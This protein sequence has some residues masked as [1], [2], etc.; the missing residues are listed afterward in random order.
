MVPKVVGSIPIT[1][2]NIKTPVYLGLLNW[3]C[4]DFRYLGCL[5]LHNVD[6]ERIIR[7]LR[8]IM[9]EV[10]RQKEAEISKESL[11]PYL[12]KPVIIFNTKTGI[13]YGIY[14]GVVDGTV[15]GI[16]LDIDGKKGLSRITPIE[17]LDVVQ[18][19]EYETL[20]EWPAFFDQITK[21]I[22]E[23]RDNTGDKVGMFDTNVRGH[24]SYLKLIAAESRL[25]NN[26]EIWN[27]IIGS[28]DLADWW[29]TH[30]DNFRLDEN[31]RT[32]YG[33]KFER[34]ILRLRE[35]ALFM[36]DTHG[37]A[38][39]KAP[40]LE[41]LHLQIRQDRLARFALRN[42]QNGIYANVQNGEELDI[43]RDK[44]PTQQ[45]SATTEV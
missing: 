31:E 22:D 7:A 20:G 30:I 9:T 40:E 15:N 28:L 38:G 4:C 27:S 5:C 3:A 36:V 29:Y 41:D 8:S 42:I 10:I 19:L 2:P 43:I 45:L 13:D 26:R 21:L 32:E 44:R 34:Q 1:R 11:V 23:L 39:H 14:A 24:L 17:G 33:R 12:G 6:R 25:Q 16:V 37:G 18:D 35:L